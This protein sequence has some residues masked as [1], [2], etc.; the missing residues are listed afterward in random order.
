M[1]NT[2]RL[3][4]ILY[5]TSINTM[6]WVQIDLPVGTMNPMTMTLK[7]QKTNLEPKQAAIQSAVKI[8][9]YFPEPFRLL[10]TGGLDSQA[11]IECWVQASKITGKKFSVHSFM[12][13]DNTNDYDL[14]NLE[15]ICLRDKIP[16]YV[17]DFDLMK[18]IE[19][20]ECREY[21]LKWLTHSPQ[22]AAHIKMF[23]YFDNGTVLMS[24]NF[25][26]E[27]DMGITANH[28]SEYKYAR[29]F[30]MH[31]HKKKVIPFFLQ[32]DCEAGSSS[33][34][35]NRNKILTLDRYPHIRDIIPE[36]SGYRVKMMKYCAM[37]FDLI[38]HA[39]SYSGFE[40]FKDYFERFYS[41]TPLQRLRTYYKGSTR[42]FD[43]F[44]RYALENEITYSHNIEYIILQDY[45]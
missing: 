39:K 23:E 6:D 22:M 31:N 8:Q 27:S 5:M 14:V 13:N 41:T 7:I 24:G 25:A 16:R 17:H 45:C 33:I 28:Y 36:K 30:N 29:E 10:C 2:L 18:F 40:K 44:H 35:F 9:K 34:Y 11:M 32:H 19:S 38:P 20:G 12:Y 1:T 26:S 37:G 4:W 3:H 42:A 21:Q 15:E 43:V